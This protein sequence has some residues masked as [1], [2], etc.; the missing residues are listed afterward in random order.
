MKAKSF[1][2]IHSKQLQTQVREIF[3]AI[4]MTHKSPI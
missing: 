1:I 4:L 3:V 2:I